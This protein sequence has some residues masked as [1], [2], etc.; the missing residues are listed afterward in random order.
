MDNETKTLRCKYCKKPIER[1]RYVWRNINGLSGTHTYYVL[2]GQAQQ[3]IWYGSCSHQPMSEVEEVEELL[4]EYPLPQ[5][6]NPF[7]E[8]SRPWDSRWR[9]KT[10]GRR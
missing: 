3:D 2:V 4:R 6:K 7:V 9:L 5:K 10:N 8:K 1:H